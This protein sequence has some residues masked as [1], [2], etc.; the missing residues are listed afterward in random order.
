MEIS[1]FSTMKD[2]ISTDKLMAGKVAH[3]Q[4]PMNGF[5]SHMAIKIAIKANPSPVKLM[6]DKPY[7]FLHSK[8][9]IVCKYQF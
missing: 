2:T 4:R 9:Q 7:R 5:H 6:D 1:I 3:T 8:Y